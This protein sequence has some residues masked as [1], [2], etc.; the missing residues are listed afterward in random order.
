MA[1]DPL[2]EPRSEFAPFQGR[3][4]GREAGPRALI[5]RCSTPRLFDLFDEETD[6]GGELELTKLRAALRPPKLANK[7]KAAGLKVV[8][9]KAVAKGT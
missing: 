6:A 3:R 1:P 7:V 9:A 4:E 8:A 5:L 2:E